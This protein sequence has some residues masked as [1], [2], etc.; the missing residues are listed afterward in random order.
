MYGWLTLESVILAMD[1]RDV[2]HAANPESKILRRKRPQ[3]AS[4]DEWLRN[5]C[6]LD[7]N[8]ASCWHSSAD[9]PNGARHDCAL[10]TTKVTARC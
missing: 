4:K 6:P 5:V 8:A 3:C 7:I 9:F 2:W 10:R 1:A